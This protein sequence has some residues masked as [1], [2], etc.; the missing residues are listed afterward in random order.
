[1]KRA[2][3]WL[4]LMALAG[5]IF[6]K[7]PLF[8][9]V[10]S[11]DRAVGANRAAFDAAAF[12]ESFWNEKLLPSL[13]DGA[14]VADAAKLMEMLRENPQAARQ[15]FGRKVGISRVRLFVLRGSGVVASVDE[16]GI[17]VAFKPQPQDSPIDIVLHTGPVFGNV[18]RDASGLLD[19]GQ[20]SNSQHLNDIS[21][22]L[23]RMIEARVI[24]KMKELAIPGQNMHFVGCAELP[25]D[26]R[27]VRP[28]KVIPLDVSRNEPRP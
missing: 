25:D 20:F 3:F 6:W 28:L 27:D 24:P 13:R 5:V 4:S 16:K 10:R 19:P 7:F 23:N 15:E 9:V 22:Q 8:Y 2:A 12:A 17:G 1:M 26:Q 21:T 11:E 18:V 14:D